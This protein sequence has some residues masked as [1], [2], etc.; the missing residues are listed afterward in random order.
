MRSELHTQRNYA[1]L[2][3]EMITF[4]TLTADDTSDFCESLREDLAK[5]QKCISDKLPKNYIHT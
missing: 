4:H 3:T 1:S 2:I 5:A